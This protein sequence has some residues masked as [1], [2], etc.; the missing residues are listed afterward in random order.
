MDSDPSAAINI[1]RLGLQ[2]LCIQPVEALHFKREEKPLPLQPNTYSHTDPIGLKER[3]LICVPQL[4]I[5]MR[6]IAL[7]VLLI[8]LTSAIQAQD[9]GDYNAG[10]LT[11]IKAGWNVI[12]A[13][14][15]KDDV[16]YQPAVE[17]WNN[18]V[19]T[20]GDL[21]Y[22]LP[23]EMHLSGMQLSG[24]S[25]QKDGLIKP[26]RSFDPSVIG[27]GNGDWKPPI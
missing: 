7:T 6:K 3:Y 12:Q 25:P 21:T 15:Q 11:G 27:T 5:Q 9:Q 16:A 10:V 24:T 4:G 13:L 19:R 26:L 2:S 14:L 20:T 22:L 18:L 1:L 23:E 17:S 8:A